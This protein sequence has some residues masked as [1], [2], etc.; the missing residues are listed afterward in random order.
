MATTSKEQ[1]RLRS[2]LI[3]TGQLAHGQAVTHWESVIGREGFPIGVANGAFHRQAAQRIGTI[4]NDDGQL[5]FRSCLENISQGG[6]VG[7]ITTAGILN[8]VNQGIEAAKSF[9]GR[10]APLAVETVN[11]QAGLLVLGI[12][13]ALRPRLRGCRARD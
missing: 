10:L 11:R 6:N 2:A 1:L 9:G 5:V 3:Q 13:Y 7:V 12:R 8:I 4:Q